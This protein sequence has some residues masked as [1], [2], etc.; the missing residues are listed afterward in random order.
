MFLKGASSDVGVLL[1]A[2][3]RLLVREIRQLYSPDPVIYLSSV[4]SRLLQLRCSRLDVSGVVRSARSI[5]NRWVYLSCM[6]LFVCSLVGHVDQSCLTEIRKSC[7]S[8]CLLFSNPS[9]RR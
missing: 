6:Q 9:L 2:L 5:S 3:H 1:G 7:D 4:S 8:K